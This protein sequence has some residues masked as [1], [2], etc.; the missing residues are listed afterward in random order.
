MQRFLRCS[1]LYL[2]DRC[3]VDVDQ[4]V[5]FLHFYGGKLEEKLYGKAVSISAIIKN[6][7]YQELHNKLAFA[8]VRKHGKPT[9]AVEVC[10]AFR[11]AERSHSLFL[12]VHLQVC[13]SVTL[14]C[15]SVYII[16]QCTAE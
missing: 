8:E 13:Y 7:K 4:A 5:Y 2:H 15:T 3:E 12:L 6:V 9:W 1:N 14:K 11:T 16:E 10:L